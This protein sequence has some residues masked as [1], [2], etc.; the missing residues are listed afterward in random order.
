MFPKAVLHQFGRGKRPRQSL[1]FSRALLIRWKLGERASLWHEALQ[2]NQR[3]QPQPTS[4]GP[5]P[6]QTQ[7]DIERMVMLGRSGQALQHLLSPGLVHDTPA[8]QLKLASKFPDPVQP[9]RH[10]T[11][12]PA[13]LPELPEE[14]VA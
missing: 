14:M 6:E 9:P 3:V 12:A 10:P 5:E 7:R 13:T 8:V 11:L 2:A 1:H 4:A